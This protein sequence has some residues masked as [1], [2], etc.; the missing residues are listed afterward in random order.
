MFNQQ[1]PRLLTPSPRAGRDRLGYILALFDTLNTT[2]TGSPYTSEIS[3]NLNAEQW[4]RI[5]AFEDVIQNNTDCFGNGAGKN[6]FAYKPLGGRWE[7]IPWDLDTAMGE[8]RSCGP[9]ALLFGN[10]DPSLSRLETHPPFARAYW[11]AI[12]DAVNGPMLTNVVGP[13]LDANY[14]ALTANGISVLS[15]DL[16]GITNCTTTNTLRNWIAQKRTILTNAL[17][18]VAAPFEI[19]NNGGN[20][21]AVT[22]QTSV[23]LL[24]KAPVEVAFLRIDAASTNA[25]TT[26]TSVTNW[27]T[28]VVLPIGTNTFIVQGYDG[29]NQILSGLSDS[30]TI[31]NKP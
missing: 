8:T 2:N 22:N 12:Q 6:M 31:T 28:T 10:Y 17:A 19:S 11:R 15:P 9:T 23:T 3:T 7:L 29:L 4:M 21:F 25:A 27:S 14:A 24:G 1:M 26:W 16:A 30:I 5:F 20:N 13:L 18:G